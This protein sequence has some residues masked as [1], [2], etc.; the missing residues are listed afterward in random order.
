MNM[1]ML[2]AW[3]LA[4]PVVLAEPCFLCTTPAFVPKVVAS[5][6]LRA[7]K[8]KEDNT[9]SQE[10]MELLKSNNVIGRRQLIRD[11]GF[12][13]AAVMHSTAAIGAEKTTMTSNTVANVCDATVESYRKG[14]KRI[15]IVG[16]A[17][18][19][20]VSAALAGNL[21]REVKVC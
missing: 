4:L 13:A 18:V 20:S 3:I 16:T 5:P 10:D 8:H 15:H 9:A 2:H 6:K 12:A 11:I 14:N 21:V 7:Y 19:S 17:H 1:T